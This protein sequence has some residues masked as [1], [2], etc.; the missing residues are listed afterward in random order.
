MT[1]L[2]IQRWYKVTTGL[3]ATPPGQ[4]KRWFD[5]YDNISCS[6]QVNILH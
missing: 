1:G 2:T 3:P 6:M 4:M 5:I